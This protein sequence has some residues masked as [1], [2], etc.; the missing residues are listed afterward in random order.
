M[1]EKI[2]PPEWKRQQEL[3]DQR[4]RN[5]KG[6]KREQGR[7]RAPIKMATLVLTI[8]DRSEANLQECYRRLKDP[9]ITSYVK[10]FKYHDA[11]QEAV[12]R[13]EVVLENFPDVLLKDI[14][15]RLSAGGKGWTTGKMGGTQ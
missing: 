2:G 12:M 1:P 3:R 8:K 7:P 10:K 6:G 9:T 14:L 13:G 5:K 4:R 11:R 15:S